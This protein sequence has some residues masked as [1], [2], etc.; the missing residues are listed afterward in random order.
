MSRRQVLASIKE[1]LEDKD[2][3]ITDDARRVANVA[4]DCTL[5]H[6]LEYASGLSEQLILNGAY[7]E[8]L[9]AGLMSIKIRNILDE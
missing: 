5:Q 7:T 6:L 8:A 2:I 4:I 1:C 3:P 9:T